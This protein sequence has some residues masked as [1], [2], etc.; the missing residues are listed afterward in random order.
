MAAGLYA[1]AW[2]LL[3]R[4][5]QP[6]FIQA[7]LLGCSPALEDR[8]SG[9]VLPSSLAG[10]VDNGAYTGRLG[11]AQTTLAVRLRPTPGR[12]PIW[13]A[14]SGR[15]PTLG[16]RAHL[17]VAWATPT[18]PMRQAPPG[19]R[20]KACGLSDPQERHRRQK[21]GQAAQGA[22]LRPVPRLCDLCPP[23][24]LPGRPGGLCG[25]VG[26]SAA[27]RSPQ[28]RWRAL[29]AA[30]GAAGVDPSARPR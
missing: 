21:A 10:V 16:T 7:V 18:Q 5:T 1:A 23:S 11:Y 3:G 2:P 20:A 22:A 27:G 26:G 15:N 8:S 24:R 13:R 14:S 19:P 12:R 25:D 4:P 9:R 29:R 17:P 30:A 6:P 28:P